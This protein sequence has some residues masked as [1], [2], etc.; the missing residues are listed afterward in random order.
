MLLV[1]KILGILLILFLASCSRIKIYAVNVLAL[2]R[3]QT[4]Y[5]D[6]S[7]AALPR[8]K[9]NVYTPKEKTE[10][11]RPVIIFFYGGGWETGSKDDY[12][13][14][15]EP[16]ISNDYVVVVPD[17]AKYPEF[18]Y[19]TFVEDGAKAVAWTYQNI[20][21]Y[22]GDP[23]KI[24]LIGHS[25]GAHLAG[26]LATN[27]DYLANLKVPK[28]I[29]RGFVGIS[30]AYDFIPVKQSYVAVFSPI[31]KNLASGMPATY[32]KDPTLPVLLIHTRQDEVIDLENITSMQTQA[33]EYKLNLD[34]RYYDS[35]THIG[36]IAAFSL[37][38]R[39]KSSLLSDV[40]TF[41]KKQTKEI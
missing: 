34:V 18:K 20:K 25:A 22:G 1:I 21:H 4:L 10:E 8:Q 32:F 6:L 31:A 38:L 7:Y 35:L 41:C 27:Q 5:R 30:G 11:L 28:E 39:S 17:Y 29:I 14:V 3:G 12:R 24:I 33:E 36:T 2:Y 15:A 13:F 9:L 26:L 37:P 23:E 19:P 16:F 40:L